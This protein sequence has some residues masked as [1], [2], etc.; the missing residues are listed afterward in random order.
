MSVEYNACHEFTDSGHGREQPARDEAW[1]RV[2]VRFLVPGSSCGGEMDLP[3]LAVEFFLP[4][5]RWSS[6]MALA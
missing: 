6:R 2:T 5:T 4:E 1:A 3:A